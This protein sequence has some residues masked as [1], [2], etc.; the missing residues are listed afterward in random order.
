MKNR[1]AILGLML[2]GGT[3]ANGLMAADH[4]DAPGSVAEPTADITDLYAWMS[5]DAENVNLVLDVFPL[6]G[7]DAAFS[8]DVVYVFHVNSSSAYGEDQTETQIR[9]Q[10]YTPT[11]IECWVGA[12]YVE[13]NASAEA[14]ITSASGDLRVFAGK[15]NDPFFMEFEGFRQ[16]TTIVKN[17]VAADELVFDDDGCPLLPPATAAALR[18]QLGS[19]ADGADASDFF[20]GADVM[21]IVIQIDKALVTSGGPLL[22][23]WASTH[24]SN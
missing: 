20:M 24:Q 14:G 2:A 11:N 21:S 7:A 12:E 19:G 17:A 16:T 3:F 23:V 22:G 6:A 4:I 9:C 10:F 5:P 18:T 13:G 15:R 1:M 8:T